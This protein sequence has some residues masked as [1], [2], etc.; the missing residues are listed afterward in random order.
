MICI[1]KREREKNDLHLTDINERELPDLLTRR[2]YVN[3]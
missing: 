2:I 1:N 3:T